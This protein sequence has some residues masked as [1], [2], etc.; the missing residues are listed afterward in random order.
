MDTKVCYTDVGA[1]VEHEHDKVPQEVASGGWKDHRQWDTTRRWALFLSVGKETSL[2]LPSNIIAQAIR[3]TFNAQFLE[4]YRTVPND[5]QWVIK[6]ND[7]NE[8]VTIRTLTSVR[9]GLI[10]AEKVLYGW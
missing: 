5:R 8:Y 3:R 4:A 2:Y 7:G 1:A 6:M 10:G 9:A